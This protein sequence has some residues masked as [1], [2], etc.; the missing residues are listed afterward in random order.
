MAKNDK[1]RKRKLP[2]FRFHASDWLTSPT[3]VLMNR[4]QKSMLVDCLCYIHESG[5]CRLK[6]TKEQIARLLN[7]QADEKNDFEIV[8]NQLAICPDDPES[9]THLKMWEWFVSDCDIYLK[10]QKAGRKGGKSRSSKSEA[11]S[12]QTSS[13]IE[14]KDKQSLYVS[15]SISASNSKSLKEE[16]PKKT[17]KRF[18]PPTLQDCLEYFVANGSNEIEAEKYLCYYDSNGWKVG[19]NKMKNWRSAAKGWIRR[20]D[21]AT[22]IA[23]KS[24]VKP[25]YQQNLDERTK[26]ILENAFKEGS[27]NGKTKN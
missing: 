10:R 25:T 20:S 11:N 8:W 3:V 18:Q 5:N 21:E 1:E 2:W 27:T 26:H 12:K 4:N 13:K 14:A 19:K 22:G 9:V 15:S 23:N 17:T 16:E 7:V 24:V 6:A